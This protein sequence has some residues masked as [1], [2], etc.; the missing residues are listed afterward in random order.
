M[1]PGKRSLQEEMELSGTLTVA[2]LVDHGVSVV[3]GIV[4]NRERHCKFLSPP[5]TRT[6]H[7]PPTVIHS[8][9]YL[10]TKG[11]HGNG[12]TK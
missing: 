9:F 12:A 7:E 1:A 2:I 3:G 6:T 4:M 8:M 11:N 5:L 10:H